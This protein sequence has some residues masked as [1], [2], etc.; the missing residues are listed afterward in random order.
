MPKTQLIQQLIKPTVRP[1]ER[2][3]VGRVGHECGMDRTYEELVEE[4]GEDNAEFLFETLCKT[5]KNYTQLTY[6]KMGV[7]PSQFEELARKEAAE[8]DFRFEEVDGNM[9][10]IQRFI[11]G[12]WD[13]EDFLIVPP[14]QTIKPAY[15]DSIVKVSSD[16]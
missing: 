12:E 2:G 4:Y 11:N 10:L 7:E 3:N 13:S 6:I 1:F 9:T 8:R 15:D 5:D 16:T 14:G